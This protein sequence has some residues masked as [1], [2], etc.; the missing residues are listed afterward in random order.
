MVR[1]GISALIGGDALS[2]SRFLTGRVGLQ[3]EVLQ[4]WVA[5][6]LAIDPATISLTQIAGDASPRRY[7]RVSR[8]R[9]A[10][11]TA[12]PLAAIGSFGSNRIA[13]SDTLIAALSPGS[14]NND[15]FLAVQRLMSTAGLR[16]PA[17]IAADLS[18]GFF[19]MEDLGDALLSSQLERRSVETWYPLALGELAKLT[20]ISHRDARLP[21]MDAGRIR[22]ELS[23]FP[24][25][26]LRGLLGLS[27]AEIPSA[28]LDSLASYL[29]EAF[30]AQTQCVVHRDFH[31]RNLMCLPDG[32]LG[33]IDFQD[34]VIGPVTYDPVSLLKDCY[35]LWHRQDQLRWLEQYRQQLARND[36]AVGTPQAFQAGFDMCGLQ[37]HLRVLGVFA[38]LHLRDGKPAYLNDLPLV[39][40]YVREVLVHYENIPALSDFS[41][42]LGA[43]VMP[44]IAKQPWHQDL[45]VPKPLPGDL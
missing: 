4:N 6:A 22:E 16:V 23:V 27:D 35:V 41:G 42:W 11:D 18:Q 38:R 39:W 3:L 24:E 9:G 12:S 25:W 28:I 26:F 19:L 33:V 7:F 43:E 29:A 1:E 8:G 20:A 15:A 31:C 37:R 21:L 44:R 5:E 17:Q 40:H 45:Q 30:S 34:A 10:A 32:G 2:W 36:L 13:E 14:E